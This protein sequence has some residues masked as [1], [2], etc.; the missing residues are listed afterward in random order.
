MFGEQQSQR[1]FVTLM[2]NQNIL[3]SFQWMTTT[4]VR[5]LTYFYATIEMKIMLAFN[6]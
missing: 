3:Q 6:S 2:E 4:P 1:K 5:I